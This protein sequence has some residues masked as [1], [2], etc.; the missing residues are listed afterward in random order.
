VDMQVGVR[1]IEDIQNDTMLM[2]AGKWHVNRKYNP[3]EQSYTD[4]VIIFDGDKVIKT[5]KQTW[6][7]YGSQ[8]SVFVGAEDFGMKRSANQWK[9]PEANA[10]NN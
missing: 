6:K 10:G 3:Q 1:K 7:Y 9:M 8:G 2:N 4:D 5:E